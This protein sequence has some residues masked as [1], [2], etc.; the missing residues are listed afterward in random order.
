MSDYGLPSGYSRSDYRGMLNYEGI[1][2]SHVNDIMKYRDNDLK[3]YC[4]SIETFII[5][6]PEKIRN[7]AF[8]KMKELGIKRGDYEHVTPYKAT[9]YDDLV[10]YINGLLEESNIIF[11]TGTFE[12][13]HD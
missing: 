4:S 7:S 13:G 1:L 10:I 6:C 12:I 5:W 2:G 11:R 8:E 3:R 9:V